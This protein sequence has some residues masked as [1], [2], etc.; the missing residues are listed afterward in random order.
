MLHRRHH[1]TENRTAALGTLGDLADARANQDETLCL[2]A[3]AGDRRGVSVTLRNLAGIE[4]HSGRP[5]RAAC[6]LGASEAIRE[7]IGAAHNPSM[8][9][10]FEQLLAG[11]RDALGEPAFSQA[12]DAGRALSIEQAV[13]LALEDTASPG[14]A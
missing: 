5:Q 3:E 4:K 2:R 1:D 13:A 14:R 6:L 7:S 9:P 8:V 10:E 11:V 12:W